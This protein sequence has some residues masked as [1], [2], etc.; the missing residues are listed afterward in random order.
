[1]R[2]PRAGRVEQ[3]G[4]WVEV[5]TMDRRPVPGLGLKPFPARD[6]ISRWEVIEVRPRAPAT[7]ATAFLDTLQR[8]LPF[9]LRAV[10]V[11][12]GGEF[13]AAF[14]AA[15]RQRRLPRLVLPPPSPQLQGH[16]ERANRTPTEEF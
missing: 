1:V 4:D 8:R 9:P 10:P 2:Q 11:D 16:V 15:C 13:A 3:P 6:V 14:E 7:A 12:G 5:D